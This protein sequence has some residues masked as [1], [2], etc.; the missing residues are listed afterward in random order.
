MKK[1]NPQLYQISVLPRLSINCFI[2]DEILFDAGIKCSYHNIKKAIHEKP[3]TKHVLTHA[4]ADHQ[5]SSAQICKEFNIPLFCHKEEV[6][7]TESGL[8]VSDYPAPT[9]IIAR[10]QQKYWAGEGHPVT[11][12][13]KEGDL[14]GNFIVIE[15]PG[16]SAGHLSFFREDDGTLII[17]DALC[18]MNLLTTIPGLQLPPYLFTSDQNQNIQ[19]LKKLYDLHPKVICFGHGPVLLNT[20]RQFEKFIEELDP[21]R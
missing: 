20:K 13:L 21:L 12:T 18:N 7:R 11:D 9:G 10:F 3:I 16:H 19:S 1:I 6:H 5:G 4:H 14:V 17:G 8:A 15:T 2:A